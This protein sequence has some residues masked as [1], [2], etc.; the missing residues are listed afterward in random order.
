MKFLIYIS[1]LLVVLPLSGQLQRKS[2]SFRIGPTFNKSRILDSEDG[3]FIDNGVL[4]G[5]DLFE[6]TEFGLFYTL[7]FKRKYEL[8]FGF[9]FTPMSAEIGNFREAEFSTGT[10]ASSS[11]EEY[12]YYVASGALRRPLQ[13]SKS[14]RLIPSLELSFN[15][16]DD[17]FL[18]IDFI[19]C[20][21]ADGADYYS[22][23]EED[24]RRAANENIGLGIGGELDVRIFRGLKLQLWGKRVWRSSRSWLFDVTETI[25][26]KSDDRVVATHRGTTQAILNNWSFG[27]GL[28][29][30]IDRK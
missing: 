30:D 19:K 17:S 10:Y 18:F 22:C 15:K 9:R 7:P 4:D 6:R 11:V 1:A 23:R 8:E 28:G 5:F 21:T 13:L 12:L 25:H 3:Y 2:W 29:I 16:V 14:V 24:Y 26:A 27:L 20:F